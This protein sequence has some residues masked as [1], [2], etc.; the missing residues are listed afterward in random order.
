MAILFRKTRR[1][2]GPERRHHRMFLTRNSEYHCRDGTCVAV[3]DLVTGKFR[4]DHPAIGRHMTGGIRFALDGSVQS[5][6]Q[7]G[8]EPHVGE[9]LFFSNGKLDEELRTSA[10]RTITR[11]PAVALREYTL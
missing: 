2:R 11:P 6:T 1:H 5:I 7:C 8:E 10:L 4:H 3:R 9:S